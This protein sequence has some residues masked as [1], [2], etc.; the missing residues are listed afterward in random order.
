MKALLQTFLVLFQALAFAQTTTNLNLD[1]EAEKS[2]GSPYVWLFNKDSGASVVCDRASS[3]EGSK[4]LHVNTYNNSTKSYL[5]YNY[6]PGKYLHEKHYI[7]ITFFVKTD[8]S[9]APIS[10]LMNQQ[11]KGSVY[12]ST[13]YA[14]STL[15]DGWK[16]YSVSNTVDTTAERV[17]FGVSLGKGEFWIDNVTVTL[18]ETVVNDVPPSPIQLPSS[19]DLKWL[20]KNIQEINLNS[21]GTLSP[22]E[23]SPIEK[24]LNEV[25]VLAIGEATHGTHEFFDVKIKLIKLLVKNYNFKV[26]AFEAPMDELNEVNKYIVEGIGRISSVVQGRS[27]YRVYDTKEVQELIEWLRLENLT[28]SKN[29]KIYF[30]GIDMQ[31]GNQAVQNIKRYLCSDS[32]L[33]SRFQLIGSEYFKL[34][35]RSDWEKFYYRLEDFYKTFLSSELGNSNVEN[36]DRK[37]I[38]QNIKLLMQNA[39]FRYDKSRESQFVRDSMMADNVLWLSQYYHDSKIILWAHNAHVADWSKAMGAYLFKAMGD[40]YFSVGL[41]AANGV[42]NVFPP[43]GTITY[44]LLSPTKET[45]EY[46]FSTFNTPAFIMSTHVAREKLKSFLQLSFRSVGTDP[47]NHQF[48]SLDKNLF[49]LFDAI[50]FIKDTTPSFARVKKGD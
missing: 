48:Q 46:Y 44:P 37:W 11:G 2:D 50:I 35:G 43:S 12:T 36:L 39:R 28:R 29:N 4:S 15:T 7:R 8:S 27:F 23:I 20:Q 5:V 17:L 34:K 45:F 10:L 9:D 32:A 31:G 16:R 13:K 19:S 40:R 42:F 26:I 33:C 30:A 24:K 3:F 38:E 6:L 1:F 22:K 14:D 25:T 18:D 47:T 41:T 21:T 49:Q